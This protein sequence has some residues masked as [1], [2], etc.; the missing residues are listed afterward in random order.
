MD[1]ALNSPYF[2]KIGELGKF[3]LI[4]SLFIKQ[5]TI[6]NSVGSSVPNFEISPRK[7]AIKIRDIFGEHLHGRRPKFYLNFIV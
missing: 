3:E 5:V 2:G 4:L 6:G 7:Y 1:Q